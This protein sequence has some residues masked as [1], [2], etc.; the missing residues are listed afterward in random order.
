[1]LQG[2][3][4]FAANTANRNFSEISTDEILSKPTLETTPNRILPKGLSK[5][6][7]IAITAPASP[8][9]L[10]EISPT[11]NLLKSLGFKVVVGNTIK[12]NS[13]EYRY[14]ASSDE[15]RAKEFMQFV[16]DNSVDAIICGR[17]GYGVMRI[18]NLIDFNKI[19]ANP[20]II[21]GFS[22]I[23]ALIN[24][25][26]NLTGIV[27]YHG[28]VATNSFDSFTLDYFKRALFSTNKFEPINIKQEDLVVINP[29]NA[30]GKL[31]GG[32]LKMLVSTLGT[33]YE[34]DSKDSILF[35]EE[36]SEHA[37]QIDRMLT[38]LILSSK[39][40]KAKAIVFGQ[41]KDLNKRTSF[42][43]TKS[44]TIKEVIEQI[45]KP[46]NIP[47][48]IGMPFG[49]IQK[50]ITLP[51]GIQANLNTANKTLTIIE[52]TVSV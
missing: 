38:Q 23:T 3:E 20:K 33:P 29:G 15:D 6:S 35:I 39:L 27:S 18:L 1:M 41:F 36:V 45:T 11:I 48:V 47:I 52:P 40:Q 25:I 46:L 9:S 4:L 42:F 32:N 2:A 24:S 21:V 16:E 17:G 44:F 8:T 34:I 14:L 37:Y 22:D 50:K 49:H 7:K 5:G 10:G 28:P 51:I 43:P 13:K 19:Q 31:V 30:Q 12:L 26:Y